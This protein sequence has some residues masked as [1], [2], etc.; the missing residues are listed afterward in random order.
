CAGKLGPADLSR[1]L[2][3]LPAPS[4][5]DV[6]V[7][8]AT[9]DDAGVFRI[10]PD[11]A[12]VQ[13]VD[14]FSPIV[15][16]PFQFGAVAAANAISDAYAMGGDPRTRLNIVCFPQRDAP[17]EGGGG[18]GTASTTSTPWGGS[19]ARRSTSSAFRS[20][21]CRWRCWARS[22]AAASTRL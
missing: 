12:L 10:A 9:A 15:D 3:T 8:T 2:A 21:T 1:V 6:L 13:T 7:G 16:D 18:R 20:A 4:H 14:F 11:L 19:R 22:S 5:P 17:M